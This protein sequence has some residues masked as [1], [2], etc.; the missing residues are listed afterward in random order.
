MMRPF[1]PVVLTAALAAAA[2]ETGPKMLAYS[3][4]PNAYFDDHAADAARLYDG[5]FFVVGSW[6]EG[7]TH[8][9][10]V[11]DLPPSDPSW[12]DK[13]ES[14]IAKLREAGAAESLL[15]VSF[16]D[17]EPWPSPETLLSAD[18]T[19]YKL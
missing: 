9:L 6:D 18:F 16:G 14:N 13:V 4:T 1:F 5:F 7:V 11:G 8:C 17:S 10:G 19:A 12:R 15:G 3:A 2:A